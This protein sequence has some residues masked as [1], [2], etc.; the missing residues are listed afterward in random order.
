MNTNQ[1][2]LS[3]DCCTAELDT[4]SSFADG[5]RNW[6]SQRFT[7]LRRYQQRRIAIAEL[8]RMSDWRLADLGIPRERIVEVVDGLIAREGPD[9]RGL[10]G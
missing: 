2:R 6:A 5:L 10:E 4:R 9:V 8:R 1:I 3:P 7:A